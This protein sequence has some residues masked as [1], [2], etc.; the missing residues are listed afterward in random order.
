MLQGLG[1]KYWGEYDSQWEI[2]EKYG[3]KLDLIVLTTYPELEY[4]TPNEIPNDYYLKIKNYTDKPIAFAEVGWN[5][6]NGDFLNKFLDLT[7]DLDKEFVMWAFLH[8]MD[9][10]HFTGIGLRNKDGTP[11][12]VWADWKALRDLP[13]VVN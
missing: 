13:Y 8:D 3:G 6:D 10:P 4:D 2:L 7:K 5:N 12:E 11:K 9:V 1:Q